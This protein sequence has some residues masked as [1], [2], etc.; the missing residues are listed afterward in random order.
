MIIFEARDGQLSGV[1][2]ESRLTAG[3][4]LSASA[5]CSATEMAVAGS[6]GWLQQRQTL[7][8]HSDQGT[9]EGT[10][11]YLSCKV[12]LSGARTRPS[13]PAFRRATIQTDP[14]PGT[15]SERH[16]AVG[17]KGYPQLPQLR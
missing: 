15:A 3:L 5:F 6:G 8:P 10:Q 7:E 1:D 14:D 12:Q 16:G 4:F 9:L 17:K 2:Q 13:R 11:E